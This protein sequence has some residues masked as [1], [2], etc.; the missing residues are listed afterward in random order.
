MINVILIMDK[1][2]AKDNLEQLKNVKVN[3][4]YHIMQLNQ[5]NKIKK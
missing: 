3:Q 2:Q 4:T 1:Y 5:F